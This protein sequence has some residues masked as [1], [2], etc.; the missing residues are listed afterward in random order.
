LQ[1]V[2]TKIEKSRKYYRSLSEALCDKVYR[3]A[4]QPESEALQL[5]P[6]RSLKFLRLDSQQ[7]NPSSQD[8][9]LP[10]REKSMRIFE[11]LKKIAIMKQNKSNFLGKNFSSLSPRVEYRE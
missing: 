8:K 11:R 9:V 10:E 4:T 1:D 2:L 3:T 6:T 7:S 5:K